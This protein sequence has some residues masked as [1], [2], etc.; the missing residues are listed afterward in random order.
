MYIKAAKIILVVVILIA[1]Q[2]CTGTSRSFISPQPFDEKVWKDFNSKRSRPGM[3]RDLVARNAL[4]GKTKDEVV[5]MLGLTRTKFTGDNYSR[6]ELE[7]MDNKD[8]LDP[9][10]AEY[11]TLNFGADG[12]VTD[13]K[14]EIAAWTPH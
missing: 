13:S 4:N 12:K 10:A 8:G 14:I 7:L 5:A 9:G 6:Y 11:L 2:G 3:A 1:I